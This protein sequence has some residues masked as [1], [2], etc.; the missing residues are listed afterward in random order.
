M[1]EDSEDSDLDDYHVKDLIVVHKD[2]SIQQNYRQTH[3]ARKRGMSL[4]R[5]GL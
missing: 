5:E 1:A 4:T 3:S 2:L